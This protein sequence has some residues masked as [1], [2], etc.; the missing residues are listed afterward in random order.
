M[1]VHVSGARWAGAA[2]LS[3]TPVNAATA[4]RVGILLLAL[5]RSLS[6]HVDEEPQLRVGYAGP[7]QKHAERFGGL[8]TDTLKIHLVGE[9]HLP[10]GL[11]LYVVFCARR[12]SGRSGVI[13]FGRGRFFQKPCSGR[14]HTGVILLVVAT[15]EVFPVLL[16]ALLPAC[17]AAISRGVRRGC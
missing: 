6:C 9:L 11:M 16:L 1:S 15:N 8:L 14:I 4:F 3:G 7:L 17:R 12:A 10:V 5:P 13:E 2:V